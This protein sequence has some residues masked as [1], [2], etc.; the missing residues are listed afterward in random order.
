MKVKVKKNFIVSKETLNT[1]TFEKMK[2]TINQFY[3]VAP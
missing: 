2:T 3:I 1:K